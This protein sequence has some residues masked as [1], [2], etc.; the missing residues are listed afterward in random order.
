MGAADRPRPPAGGLAQ[1]D[2]FHP[3]FLYESL[4]NLGVAV[5]V[6]WADRRF[7]LGHGRAFALYV[8]AYP[9][10]RGWIEMMRIDEANIILGLRVNE[11][12]S[13]LVFTAAVLYIVVSAWRRPG[14]EG[15]VDP[16]PTPDAADAGPADDDHSER[17]ARAPEGGPAAS[18]EARH[19]ATAP[20]QR[21]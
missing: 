11:W 3:T 20:R 2:T 17:D 13:L 7:R 15:I 5:L 21:R 6:I 18:T 4:W 19:G 14:R 8:A 9:L 16:Q 10:G 12:M 1:Y